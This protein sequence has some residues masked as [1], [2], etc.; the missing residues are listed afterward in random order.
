MTIVLCWCLFIKPRMFLETCSLLTFRSRMV[1]IWSNT[2]MLFCTLYIGASAKRIDVTDYRTMGSSRLYVSWHLG[3]ATIALGAKYI[4]LRNICAPFFLL[5][6]ESIHQHE[7]YLPVDTFS[8]SKLPLIDQV[9]DF[10]ITDVSDGGSCFQQ[11]LVAGELCSL[12]GDHAAGTTS[13]TTYFSFMITALTF[14]AVSSTYLAIRGLFKSVCTDIVILLPDLDRSRPNL[15][16]VILV[17][18]KSN[19]WLVFDAVTESWESSLIPP[20]HSCLVPSFRA[21]VLAV[22][23]FLELQ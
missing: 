9:S 4:M 19:T 20:A 1:M 17:E 6:V 22:A 2:R 10:D 13:A 15:P 23:W 16:T 8:V 5:V 18:K 3:H 7:D 21:E 12:R 11:I 14:N